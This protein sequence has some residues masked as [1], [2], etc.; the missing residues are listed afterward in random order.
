MSCNVNNALSRPN[1]PDWNIVPVHDKLTAALSPEKLVDLEAL[2]PFKLSLIQSFVQ[3]IQ[4]L[5]AALGVSK[6]VFEQEHKRKL[7]AEQVPAGCE[8]CWVQL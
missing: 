6:E 7:L 8:N 3:G 1:A 5:E 4:S 2:R